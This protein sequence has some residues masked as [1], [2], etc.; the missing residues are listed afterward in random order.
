MPQYMIAADDFTDEDALERRLLVRDDHL[1]RMRIEKLKGHFIIG[2]AKLDSSGKMIGSM[3]LV[4]MDNLETLNN[5]LR[6][7]PYVTGK[8]WDKIEVIPFRVAGV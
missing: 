3:L 6:E 1:Q 7:D 4:E 5:W 2:G 8:V